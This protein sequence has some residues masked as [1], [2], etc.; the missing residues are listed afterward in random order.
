MIQAYDPRPH[1]WIALTL[2]NKFICASDELFECA[3][4]AKEK[5]G[6]DF[7]TLFGVV[8]DYKKGE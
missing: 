6:E 7:Y 8:E 2:D 4:S 3:D 1:Q 5:A